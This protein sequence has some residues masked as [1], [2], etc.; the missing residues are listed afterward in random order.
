MKLAEALNLRADM[1]KY[2][3]QLRSRL[4]DN[5]KVQEGDQPMEQPTVLF[6]EL[7]N[8]LPQWESL[9][10]RINMTNAQV[11][12]DG[13]TMTE[14]LAEKDVL[15]RKL[16]IYRSAYS[17]A[18]VRNDRYTRNEIRFVSTIDGESLQKK[19]DSMSKQ[20]RELDMKIQQTNWSTELMD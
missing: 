20:Y 2:V 16:E 12:I 15:R 10:V 9:I 8:V 14:L 6:T 17:R 4:I 19:I 3:D 11:K 7:N 13:K 5:V 18:I 1:Q